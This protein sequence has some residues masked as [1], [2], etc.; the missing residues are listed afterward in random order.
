MMLSTLACIKFAPVDTLDVACPNRSYVAADVA[1]C[2][3]LVHSGI[4]CFANTSIWLFVLMLH[5]VSAVNVQSTT[6]I[7]TVTIVSASMLCSLQ[8]QM[9]TMMHLSMM[10]LHLDWA[11]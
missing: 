1:P 3:R 8:M 7:H 6:H 5:V 9:T 2:L 4:F 10:M 11:A